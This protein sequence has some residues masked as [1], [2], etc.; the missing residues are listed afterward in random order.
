MLHLVTFTPAGM[1]HYISPDNTHPRM[2]QD[3]SIELHLEPQNKFD[4]FAVEIFWGSQVSGKL[5]KIGYV[6]KPLNQAIFALL[7]ANYNLQAN[8]AHAGSAVITIS[9]IEEIS[10]LDNEIPF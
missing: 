4:N 1:R 2:R 3:E 10:P 6:P 5:I 9:L 7:K 8:I